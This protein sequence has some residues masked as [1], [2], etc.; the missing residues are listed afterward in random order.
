MKSSTAN[1][2]RQDLISRP[3]II[4][5]GQQLRDLSDAALAALVQFNHPEQIFIRG[6]ILVR[7]VVD[8]HGQPATERVGLNVLKGILARAADWFRQDVLS[9]LIPVHPPVDIVNDILA[10]GN[11]PGIPVLDSIAT[12]PVLTLDGEFISEPGYHRNSGIYYTGKPVAHRG[13]QTLEAATTVLCDD[14]LGDFPFVDD[15]SLAHAIAMLCIP[16]VRAAIDGPTPLHLV[17]SPTP[18]TGKS[19]LVDTCV[20]PFTSQGVATTTGARDVD[21][22]R[23][24]ITS[25][26]IAARIHVLIDNLTGKLD[27]PALA[28]AITSRTWEDRALGTQTLVHLPQ[29]MIWIATG[30]NVT[31]SSELARRSIWIRLDAKSERPWEITSFRH[32]NLASWA[33]QNRLLLQRSV[34]TVV[35]GWL[36]AGQPDFRGKPLG[37]FESW[38]NVIGG[39]LD[40][41]GIPGFLGNTVES[42]N[43]LD[44]ESEMWGALVAQWHQRHSNRSIGVDGLYDMAELIL[45]ELLSGGSDRARRTSFGTQLRQ[46]VDRVYGS[47]QISK[48]TARRRGAAQYRLISVGE[49]T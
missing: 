2:V 15:T 30:N 39:L 8:E 41:A 19:L 40:V 47:W 38:S 1:A 25:L 45:P 6:G 12:A 18:G 10:R 46:Q 34:M 4:V 28:A 3:E 36:D 17:D 37:G 22:W 26:L 9:D 48:V 31:L 35:Q 7:V 49:G 43:C 32:P 33:R 23:K 44:E 16:F 14:L 24:K 20:I 5:T 29:R 11:W 21:E 13:S 27:S 42:S